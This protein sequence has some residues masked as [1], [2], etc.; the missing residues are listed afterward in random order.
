[1]AADRINFFNEDIEFTLDDASSIQNW[2]AD[3][4]KNYQKI[5]GD[6]NYIFC[7]DSYLN[8]INVSYLSHDTY[9]DIITFN[10]SVDDMVVEADIYISIDRVKENAAALSIDFDQEIKRV[11]IHGILHLLG[12]ED[13]SETDKQ[14][15][16][17]KEDECLEMIIKPKT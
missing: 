14:Q 2:I 7:S 13:H 11:M 5:V 1:M 8:D 17:K 16:R 3:V 15:M 10:Q 9:T 6:I 12:F 4:I